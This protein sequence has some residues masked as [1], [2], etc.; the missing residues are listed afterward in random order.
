M[1][2]FELGKDAII[3]DTGVMFPAND[4]LGVDLITYGD[5]LRFV[6]QVAAKNGTGA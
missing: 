2:V 6:G 4:M 1:T 3:I 5:L